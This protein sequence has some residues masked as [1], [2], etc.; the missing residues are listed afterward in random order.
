MAR[1]P[2]PARAEPRLITLALGLP[3]L[4][5]EGHDRSVELIDQL[6][7]FGVEQHDLVGESTDPAPFLLEL[8]A[9]AGCAAFRGGELCLEAPDPR[10]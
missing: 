5:V 8:V 9:V 4:G 6:A 1:Q 10:G 3:A 7:P 2:R